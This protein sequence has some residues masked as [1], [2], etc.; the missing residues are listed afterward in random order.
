MDTKKDKDADDNQEEDEKDV[1]SAAAQ[2]EWPQTLSVKNLYY[3]VPLRGQ[4]KGLMTRLRSLIVTISGKKVKKEETQQESST[5][6]LLNGVEA[7]FR[8][9]RMCCLMG[10]SGA[11]KVREETVCSLVCRECTMYM[12][13]DM[14]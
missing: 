9:G 10:T 1:E 7:Q 3:S 6:T 12:Y 2:A 5:L 4:R 14:C 13:T 8:R 11:G